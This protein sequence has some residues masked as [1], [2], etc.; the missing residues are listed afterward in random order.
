MQKHMGNAFAIPNMHATMRA[1]PASWA[2]TTADATFTAK[3]DGNTL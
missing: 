1:S 2:A 3:T